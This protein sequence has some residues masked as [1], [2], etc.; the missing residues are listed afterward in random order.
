MQAYY[1]LFQCWVQY[2]IGFIYL[3]YY[4]YM[5]FFL[6][7]FKCI[8]VDVYLQN[9]NQ[10]YRKKNNVELINVMPTQTTMTRNTNQKYCMDT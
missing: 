10:Y 3:L 1:D 9:L 5:I 7:F 4:N 8:Y 6:F 2:C